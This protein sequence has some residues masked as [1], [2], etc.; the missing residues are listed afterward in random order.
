MLRVLNTIILATALGFLAMLGFK[1]WHPVRINQIR[2]LQEHEDCVR[3]LTYDVCTNDNKNVASAT[4]NSCSKCKVDN[5]QWTYVL[6]FWDAV[7]Q[8]DFCISGHC[9]FFFI[10]VTGYVFWL[11]LAALVLMAFWLSW[12]ARL[13]LAH[14]EHNK[15]MNREATLGYYNTYKQ[16]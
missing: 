16:K 3:Y 6:A 2:R 8:T 11:M 7:G 4:I 9:W 12:T 10:N 1:L 14:W 13:W 5:S 15:F